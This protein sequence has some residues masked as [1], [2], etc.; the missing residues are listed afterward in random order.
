MPVALFRFLPLADIP[1][2]HSPKQKTIFVQLPVSVS[3]D[4]SFANKLQELGMASDPHALNNGEEQ[5]E[6]VTPPDASDTMDAMDEP[7][8]IVLTETDVPVEAAKEDSLQLSQAP[9]CAEASLELPERRKRR[10]NRKYENGATFGPDNGDATRSRQKDRSMRPTQIGKVTAES[11]AGR[12]TVDASMHMHTNM[13][14]SLAMP[15]IRIPKSVYLSLLGAHPLSWSFLPQSSGTLPF[16]SQYSYSLLL[17]HRELIHDKLHFHI[18][19]TSPF[20]DEYTLIN[21]IA[22]SLRDKNGTVLGFSIAAPCSDNNAPAHSSFYIESTASQLASH[23]FDIFFVAMLKVL[24]SNCPKANE[25]LNSF[26]LESCSILQDCLGLV[27]LSG[28]MFAGKSI[29]F[30][31]DTP[32]LSPADVERRL[33]EIIPSHPQPTKNGDVNGTHLLSSPPK[34]IAVH[35]LPHSTLHI[36]PGITASFLTKAFGPDSLLR[37]S[38]IDEDAIPNGFSLSSGLKSAT[39]G[40]PEHVRSNLRDVQGMLDDALPRH[41][42]AYEVAYRELEDMVNLAQVLARISPED[43]ARRI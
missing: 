5:A 43:V 19:C 6:E 16:N 30:A 26:C 42:K 14:I 20:Y 27:C 3:P 36:L 18:K 24:F 8:S 12:G 9:P 38:E 17:G 4:L 15:V 13:A 10:R 34:P 22:S 32:E 2:I 7:P 25:D 31:F 40:M 35:Q 41:L 39:A 28:N 29:M 1:H 11:A 21:T 23:G 33:T 37:A